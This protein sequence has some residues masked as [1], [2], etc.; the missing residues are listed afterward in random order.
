MAVDEG[1]K[2][3]ILDQLSEFGG[4]Q[5]R[6][7]FGGIGFFKEGTMFAMIGGGV[8]RLRADDQT[9]PDFEAHGME[10]FNPYPDKGRKGMPYWEVPLSVFEDKHE[11]KIWATKAY[12]AAL[13]GKK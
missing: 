2:E 11:L 8:F 13:R 5:S 9:V 1:Y 12:E 3:Y 6:K 10:P 7:M 4:V